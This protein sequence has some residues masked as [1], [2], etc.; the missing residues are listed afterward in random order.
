MLLRR[1]HVITGLGTAMIIASSTLTA[2]PM[3]AAPAAAYTDPSTMSDADF[4][5]KLNL[6]HPGMSAV[7]DDVVAGDYEAAKS[8]LLGYY[9]ARTTP[10]YL[11]A[12]TD[13]TG[14]RLTSSADDL[15]NYV[16]TF[17]DGQSQNFAGDIDWDYHWNPDDPQEYGS[18]H[19]YV[20]DF[21]TTYIL[22]PAYN[23]LPAADP[24][25]ADYAG[26]WFAF[27]LEWIADKGN[28]DDGL[29]PGSNRLDMAK[30]LSSWIL[31]F[32]TFKHD[33]VLDA[34]ALTAFLKHT[35][36]MSDRLYE[37][38]ERHHGNNWYASIA[39]SVYV[40]GVYFP[41]FNDAERWRTRGESVLQKYLARKIKGD[42]MNVEPTEDYHAYGLSLANTARKVGSMNGYD[43][44]ADV[45]DQ[46]ER[47]AEVLVDLRLPNLELP[48]LGD[49]A[50]ATTRHRALMLDL[51]D[52]FDRDDLRWVATGGASGTEPANRSVLYADS[53][54]AM[55][56]GWSTDDMYALIENS[57]TEYAASHHHPDDLSMVAYAYGKR[58]LVDPGVYDYQSTGPGPWL[59][60][61][62]EAHN[63]VEVNDNPQSA[64]DRKHISWRSNDGFD[65]YHGRHS[66]Y[67]PI[68]HDRKVFFVK[69]GFW[70]VSDLMTGS[71]ITNS[72][73]QLWHFQPTTLTVDPATETTRTS[74]SGEANLSIVPADPSTVTPQVRS[75][76]YSPAPSSVSPADYVAYE[77][78]ATGPA[79]FDAVIYPDPAGVTTNVTVD[80]LTTGVAP[81]TATAL[82]LGLGSG[83]SAT[84]YLSHEATPT[85]RSFGGYGFDGEVAYI[86]RDGNGDLTTVSLADGAVL[87]D[88]TADLVNASEAVGD[89]SITYAG[90][91][92]ELTSGA[93]LPASVTVYAPGVTDVLLN[94]EPEAFS[95]D[96]DHITITGP[97]VPTTGDVV[98]ADAF[99]ATGLNS[100]HW[101]YYDFGADG[102]E[103]EHGTWD[104]ATVNGSKVYR[105]SDVSAVEART[106]TTSGWD[107]VLIRT[108]LTTTAKAG[109]HNGTGVYARYQDAANH[110]LFRYY[111]NGGSP[112]LQIVKRFTGP[113]GFAE[114][115]LASTPFT[116]NHDTSYTMQAV[117]S[118]DTL[119]L[120]INGIDQLTAHDSDLTTGTAGLHTHRRNTHFD[121][122][123]ITD[124]FGVTGLS[125][126]AWSYDDAAGADGFEPEHGTWDVATVNGSKVYRQ[127]DVSAVE[128]RTLTTSGWDNVLIRTDL[129]TTAKAG[130]H[131]GTGVYARYQDAANHYLFRYYT[132]GGSPELQ[133]VKRFTGPT[134][135]AETVLASTP[136]TMNHDTSY[137]MQAV[138]SND[139]LRLTI[140]GI[141]Q[142][143]AHDSD[144]TTGTAGLHTHRRNTHFDNTTITEPVDS[145]TWVVQDGYVRVD[146]RDL[147][148]D[149]IGDASFVASRSQNDFGDVVGSAQVSID[150]WGSGPAR[151]GITLRTLNESNSY[152]FVLY[153]SGSDVMLRIE[154]VVS[155]HLSG[156]EPV[157]LAEKAFAASTRTSYDITAVAFRDTLELHVNGVK[158][159][160]AHDTLVSRG[161]LGLMAENATA[162]FDDVALMT[163]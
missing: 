136:F 41:E 143:T 144:L 107:N 80:R 154:R 37:D 14:N 56:T 137:T 25:R 105:Q 49:S 35:W 53:F 134:G 34:D 109:D 20:L 13:P 93:T 21:M 127:S 64:I 23:A 29:G 6:D 155:G 68:D 92:L 97:T 11:S 24:K 71:S 132:N 131:N 96:G 122:T 138:A 32:S 106:L 43:V 128:A 158:H 129:T 95:V 89:L 28:V 48:Q 98:I 61:T 67:A 94:S 119:R 77:K 118:N 18:N 38:V 121:N 112:E 46:L 15:V 52:Q 62:T 140:N 110:Y 100:K 99:D 16:F 114:T 17:I 139:T 33:Q 133:I 55:R 47:A 104:V 163:P 160:V 76:H 120:T 12:G 26:T 162:R 8:S 58:L 126:Q 54:A 125:N 70:I 40:T 86:E 75:G 10:T 103:P 142:L 69:P 60:K 31:A 85:S 66:D 124:A 36:Q 44:L 57:S 39:R 111:T 150:S 88:G 159:L 73:E 72:Y 84:Y 115:V 145:A 149:A 87:T 65:F 108:D 3:A 51:A 146:D 9:R 147:L 151:A 2:T 50:S 157:V 63:T 78:S 4:F 91:T 101:N 135:F 59:R 27:A 130:D 81:T 5:A 82:Q 90:T 113:T 161:G 42:G 19:Y 74:F 45:G 152:R 116:M 7:R 153:N 1:R 83:R 22:A 123:T 117:A 79:S 141:D 102:F 148:T 156:A 30:R